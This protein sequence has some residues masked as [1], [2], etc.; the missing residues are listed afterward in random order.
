MEAFYQFCASIYLCCAVLPFWENLCSWF[1]F[2]KKIWKSLGVSLS[3]VPFIFKPCGFG[4]DTFFQIQEP[5]SLVQNWVWFHVHITLSP[6]LSFAKFYN[7]LD[8]R[9]I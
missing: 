7:K 6:I 9:F 3:L 1:L 8:L 4:F 2:F 5:L